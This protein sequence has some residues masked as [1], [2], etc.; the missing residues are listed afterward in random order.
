MAKRKYYA[1]LVPP[2]RDPARGG[3]NGKKG[4]TDNW[5]ECQGIV[6]GVNG[7]KFKSFESEEA[8]EAWLDA[9]ADYKIKNIAIEDGIYFD[10]G[11][12]AGIGVEIQVA[13][14]TGKSLLKENLGHDVTNN[15]GELTACKKA[16][17]IAIT[18]L[19][20]GSGVAKKVFGDS[21]LVV[22]YWSKGHIKYEVGEETVNLAQE[23][24]ILRKEFEK[25]GGKIILISGGANPADLGFHKG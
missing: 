15:F 4:V 16:L 19:R 6:A 3:I 18:R 24:K 17:E 25:L 20:Q 23:V 2:Q 8:A 1:Y 9:G 11:T 22:E 10:A 7:A 12:G 5:P 21:K 13:E 14:K